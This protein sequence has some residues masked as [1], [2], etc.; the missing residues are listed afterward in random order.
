MRRAIAS[1]APLLNQTLSTGQNRLV[2]RLTHPAISLH[3]PGLS[4]DNHHLRL[5]DGLAIDTYYPSGKSDSIAS[6]ENLVIDFDFKSW[7]FRMWFA[8]CR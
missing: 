8:L 7:L 1:I 4:Q 2:T 5:T 3:Y 6:G